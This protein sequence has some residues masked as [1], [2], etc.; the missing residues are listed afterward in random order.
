MYLCCPWLTPI[1][2]S[3]P[4]LFPR[5]L[6]LAHLAD[7]TCII[8]L[9]LEAHG[10]TLITLLCSCFGC[11]IWYIKHNTVKKSQNVIGR[12]TRTELTQRCLPG[13]LLTNPQARAQATRKI[14]STPKS[15]QG[16]PD[17]RQQNSASGEKAFKSPLTFEAGAVPGRV[18]RTTFLVSWRTLVLVE[19]PSGC[20]ICFSYHTPLHSLLPCSTPE[21][22]LFG[23]P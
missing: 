17:W 3:V 20:N 9:M 8:W 22:L 11:N 13:N 19:Q 23:P 5:V 6:A 21:E 4:W 12:N 14:L 1:Q 18:S 10:L 2:E 15:H 7:I 16:Q